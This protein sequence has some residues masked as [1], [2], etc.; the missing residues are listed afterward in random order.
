MLILRAICGIPPVIR[1]ES[2]EHELS[3]EWWVTVKRTI[4]FSISDQRLELL[5]EEGGGFVEIG[6]VEGR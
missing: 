4:K 3:R 2:S 1:R 6:R 5:H